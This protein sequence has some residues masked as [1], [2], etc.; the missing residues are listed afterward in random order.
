MTAQAGQPWCLC[1]SCCGL[2]GG[3]LGLI[4]L[5][6]CVTLLLFHCRY[7][8]QSLDPKLQRVV[9][10]SVARGMAYLHTRIPPILHLVR[11]L[12]V[13]TALLCFP[14]VPLNSVSVV[15]FRC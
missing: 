11:Q 6:V 2:S 13:C 10:I 4:A 15:T 9:A 12:H 3:S 14:G 8:Q 1:L 7:Q 5:L